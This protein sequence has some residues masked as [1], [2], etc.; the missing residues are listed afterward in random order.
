MDDCLDERVRFY[1]AILSNARARDKYSRV[2]HLFCKT[3][4]ISGLVSFVK[5]V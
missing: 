5:G 3:P 4:T 2:L 1:V